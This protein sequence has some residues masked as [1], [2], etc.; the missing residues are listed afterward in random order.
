MI[1]LNNLLN[2]NIALKAI[3]ILLL[4][5][6]F[7]F[8]AELP[9]KHT[10]KRMRSFCKTVNKKFKKF[11]WN[12]I[13]CNPKTWTW[14]KKF[15][16]VNKNPLIYQVFGNKKAINNTTLFMCGI[17]G[18]EHPSVYQCIKLVVDILFSSP[19]SYKNSRVVIAPIINPDGFLRKRPTRQNGRG[20]DVNRNFPTKDFKKKALA[21]WKKKYRSTKRKYPGKHGGSEIETQFQMMLIDKFNPQKIVT[22][23]SPYGWLD[24]DDPDSVITGD[25][26]DGF[27]FKNFK[28]EAKKIASIMSKKS[29]NF[30]VMNFK[31][32]PGSL[33]NYAAFERGIPTYTL[34]LANS[35]PHRAKRYWRKMR[36]A[37]IS[38][39]KYIL[40]KKDKVDIKQK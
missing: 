17:H 13:I 40:N 23:H 30:R 25:E 14:D 21:Q 4:S 33:G 39:I 29:G 26:P 38:A 24:V 37:Y 20:V 16:T 36:Q 35:D 1:R 12:D 2:Y 10:S 8:T 19:S 32:Y 9:K 6:S 28:T 3:L 11:Y 22:V 15:T 5:T 7:G 27:E 31:I 18:D 34:E